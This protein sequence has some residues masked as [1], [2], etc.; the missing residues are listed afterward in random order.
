MDILLKLDKNLFTILIVSGGSFAENCNYGGKHAK[1]DILLFMND[2]ILPKISD[3]HE[4][5]QVTEICDFVGS[6]QITKTPKKYYG[7][8][9]MFNPTGHEKNDFK[10]IYYPQ[11]QLEAGRS[12]FPS[13]FLFG[14]KKSKWDKLGG[15][16]ENFRTG[17]EDVDFGVRAMKNNFSMAILDL[18]V[19]HKESESD[20]RFKYCN[21]NCQLLDKLYNQEY[22]RKLYE[23]TNYCI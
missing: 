16:N 10:P 5:C 17:Y 22:Q 7:I 9:F 21:E 20:G 4:I 18:E 23:N 11:I 6:T 12:L 1:T 8:G 14:I 2:D 13:G 3:I 15:Y 19:Q